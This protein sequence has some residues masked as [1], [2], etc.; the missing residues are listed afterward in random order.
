MSSFKIST[1]TVKSNNIIVG[2]PNIINPNINNNP[3]SDKYVEQNLTTGKC[4]GTDV[5]K[6]TPS[7]GKKLHIKNY[8]FTNHGPIEYYINNDYSSATSIHYGGLSNNTKASDTNEF[9]HTDTNEF[10]HTDTKEFQHTDNIVKKLIYQTNQDT[11]KYN[12]TQEDIQISLESDRL[13]INSPEDLTTKNI[14]NS[15]WG[16]FVDYDNYKND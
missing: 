5:F 7:S 13:I 15:Y 9:L 14:K 16:L 8:K 1:N 2:N 10:L 12:N 6:W 4:C 3:L 11:K